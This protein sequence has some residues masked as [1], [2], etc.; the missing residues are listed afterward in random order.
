MLN[1]IQI[2]TSSLSYKL[3]LPS[4]N[5][6]IVLQIMNCLVITSTLSLSQRI[7]LLTQWNNIKIKVNKNRQAV[8]IK[9]KYS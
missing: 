6:I 7:N 4:S 3:S 2:I 8:K 1:N 9:A 5:T